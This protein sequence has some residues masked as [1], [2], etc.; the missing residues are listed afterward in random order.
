MS[1]GYFGQSAQM[2]PRHLNEELGN[3]SKQA[4]PVLNDEIGYSTQ[5]GQAQLGLGQDFANEALSLYPQL[6][7]AEQAATTAQRAQDAADL[8]KYGPKIQAALGK[9][10]PGWQSSLNAVNNA[11]STAMTPTPLL[12]RLNTSATS[13]LNTAD[14]LAPSALR[15]S[16]TQG[17]QD[18]LALGGAL[19][20]DE[21]RDVDQSSRAAF[22]ARGLEYSDPAIATEALNTHAAQ[23]QRLQQREQYAAQIQ[24]LGQSED[25]ALAAQRAQLGQ[26]AGMVQ[27]QNQ[28]S[29]TAG[30]QF[31]LNTQQANQNALNPVLGIYGQRTAVSPTAA[32]SYL[33]GG[34]NI[35]GAGPQ[36]MDPVLSY[37]SDL[38]NTNFNSDA[39]TRISNANNM[40]AIH[41]AIIGAV[42]SM[43]GAAAKCWVAREVFGTEIV[44]IGKKPWLKWVL[45]RG[46][47]MSRKCP[48]WLRKLY[49][50]RGERFASWLHEHARVKACVR[51]VMERIVEAERKSIYV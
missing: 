3:I 23:Q 30:Q 38:Y 2:D 7:T 41:G 37:G 13:A 34:P 49:F 22:A 1:S 31:L 27:G 47:L 9:I 48:T 28:Q 16:L 18:Q 8:S 36:A 15:T 43:A 44:M 40:A 26:F 33:S 11:A 39:A 50:A 25:S 10:N 24:Q 21:L 29:T 35:I 19:S 20:A 12:G 51:S 6:V 45:F 4:K 14:N 42:G 17:A 32:A 46:W 5:I